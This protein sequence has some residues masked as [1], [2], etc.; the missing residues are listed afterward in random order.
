[1]KKL[2]C[3]T[4]LCIYA[5]LLLLVPL[6][7]HAGQVSV[8]VASN[9]LP[10]VQAM[11]SRFE[12]STG[13]MLRISSGS[14]GKLYA[15]IVNGAPY[16]VFLAANE[17]EPKRLQD[18]QLIVENTRF[19]YALGQLVAWSAFKQTTQAHNLTS[20]LTEKSTSRIAIANPLTAPYGAAAK[21]V[22][23]KLNLWHSLKTK[24]VRGENISQAYQFSTSKNARV[25]FVAMS[26]VIDK[27]KN[28]EG[29][30]WLVPQGYYQPI[31]QQVVLLNRAKTNPA[32]LAF[33]K[34]LRSSYARDL[35]VKKFG[36]GVEQQVAKTTSIDKTF[37]EN[38][39]PA[40]DQPFGYNI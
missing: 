28:D 7:S 32:A 1:M 29:Q 36:Y 2:L 31:R 27:I 16:D 8:A 21:Q 11:R 22:L 39:S 10:A 3:I 38:K 23:Q 17:R 4:N 18:A 25:G 20:V 5:L 24:I 33:I 30:Y 12:A 14:T 26:Q 40:I 13:H 37:S 34:F 19:T 15:H 9:A 35:L 6:Q